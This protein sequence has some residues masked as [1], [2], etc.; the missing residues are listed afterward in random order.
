[1]S[2][3]AMMDAIQAYIARIDRESQRPTVLRQEDFESIAVELG[4]DE[5][6][7]KELEN[8]ADEHMLKGRGY[9]AQ[10][11]YAEAIE[12]Y[13]V[14]LEL[15][16]WCLEPVKAMAEAHVQAWEASGQVD[17]QNRGRHLCQQWI[18]RVPAD[19]APIAQT[20]A[21]ETDWLN[22]RTNT[23]LDHRDDGGRVGCRCAKCG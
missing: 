10:G 14:A 15:E 1:M 16:P 3:K 5:A 19:A 18:E 8:R 9:R 7:R 2:N 22:R 4:L 13:G 6:A 17:H 12:A 11:L 21:D 20:F 23:R